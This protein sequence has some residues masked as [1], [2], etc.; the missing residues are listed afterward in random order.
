MRT[1]FP[2]MLLIHPVF[3]THDRREHQICQKKSFSKFQSPFQLMITW[4]APWLSIQVNWATCSSYSFY[5]LKVCIYWPS[6]NTRPSSVLLHAHGTRRSS[7]GDSRMCIVQGQGQALSAKAPRRQGAPFRPSGEAR[8]QAKRLSAPR[9]TLSTTA[10][11]GSLWWVWSRLLEQRQYDFHS[12][13]THATKNFLRY[14]AGCSLVDE[15]WK[16][17]TVGHCFSRIFK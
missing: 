15:G 2:S 8:G 3:C 7:G 14:R 12:V 10:L 16:T 6:L 17:L 1:A 13:P 9:P 11:Q 4:G 5:C